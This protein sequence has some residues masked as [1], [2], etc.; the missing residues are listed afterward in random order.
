MRQTKTLRFFRVE[1]VD[2]I[3]GFLGVHLLFVYGKILYDLNVS[4][5]ADG[6]EKTLSLVFAVVYAVS[7]IFILRQK[8]P[9]WWKV[10]F[11]VF[12]IVAVFLWY[13]RELVGELFVW[14]GSGMFSLFTGSITI[15]L[16]IIGNMKSGKK[17]NFDRIVKKITEHF[18]GTIV[19]LNEAIK[20]KDEALERYKENSE[21]DKAKIQMLEASL[22]KVTKLSAEAEKIT[23]FWRVA[24][25]LYTKGVFN[26]STDNIKRQ[27]ASQLE[28]Q[29]NS[30]SN[31]AGFITAEVLK[32]H[33]Q[34]NLES[35]IKSVQLNKVQK[36]EV[37]SAD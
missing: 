3:L 13:N 21:L 37:S 14:L 6:I 16:G 17:S 20:K 27:I 29:L 9:F 11:A 7:T 31:P 24:F 10:C 15:A 4:I 33:E 12:D 28:I 18:K 36:N 26:K 30:I 34:G 35:L 22:E 1:P 2:V 8:V 23:E 25:M 5:F 32:Y 19:T